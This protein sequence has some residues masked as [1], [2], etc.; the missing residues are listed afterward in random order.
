MFHGCVCNGLFEIKVYLIL[1]L[2]VIYIQDI[3]Y[4]NAFM[5]EIE[6]LKVCF[7]NC[8]LYILWDPKS[9]PK[10]SGL[11][12][13]LLVAPRKYSDALNVKTLMIWI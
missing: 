13:L 2:P 7:R 6:P 4:R 3:V 5:A 12:R 11:W 8:S 9:S 10:K 1:S